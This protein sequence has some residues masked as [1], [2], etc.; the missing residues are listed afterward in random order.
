M[1]YMLMIFGDEAE[2]A[3][4]GEAE[5]EA[6]YAEHGA[7]SEAMTQAGVLRGGEELKPST[8]A[9]TVRFGDGKPTIVDGPFIETREHL[10]GYYLIEVETLEE[11]LEWAAKMPGMNSGAVEVRPCG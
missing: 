2:W 8:T 6:I 9:R 10:G 4:M 5:M 1:K 7:Y 3:S 11:A